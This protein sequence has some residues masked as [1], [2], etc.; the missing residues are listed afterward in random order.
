[1]D[2]GDYAY[3]IFLIL[4]AIFSAF[5]KKKKKKASEPVQ[6]ERPASSEKTP[7]SEIFDTLS[8]SIESQFDVELK[9][10]EEVSVERV[11]PQPKRTVSAPV[12]RVVE[13]KIVKKE[14]TK[15]V[16]SVKIKKEPESEAAEFDLRQAVIQSAIL[17]RPYE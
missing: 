1:M 6:T 15:P 11:K 16:P 8:Q 14:P 7:M 13:K 17:N 2:F 4:G 9:P 12:E 3:I 10:R 5:N